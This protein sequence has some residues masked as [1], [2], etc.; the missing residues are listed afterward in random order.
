LIFSG[1]LICG[2]ENRIGS[3]KRVER[4]ASSELRNVGAWH[5]MHILHV[6]DNRFRVRIIKVGTV[7][8]STLYMFR[9][10]SIIASGTIYTHS[11]E[12]DINQ[13]NKH[14]KS[15]VIY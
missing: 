11:L 9:S 12:L 4:D 14:V 6:R 15:C 10:R 13:Y 5:C 7:R 3:E 1:S 2:V 8:V